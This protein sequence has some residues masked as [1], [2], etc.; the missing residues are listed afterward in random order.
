MVSGP[1][2]QFARDAGI[3]N[4]AEIDSATLKTGDDP[5]A[6]RALASSRLTRRSPPPP[7][8]HIRWL[9]PEGGLSCS[10]VVAT[11]LFA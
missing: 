8:S 5:A 2:E 7:T 6:F 9:V 1:T 4:L 3:S 10:H 11:L